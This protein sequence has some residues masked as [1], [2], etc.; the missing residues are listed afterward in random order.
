MRW[1]WPTV[2]PT[3]QVASGRKVSGGI[4]KR[5]SWERY[6]LSVKDHFLSAHEGNTR[7]FR[8]NSHH[9]DKSIIRPFSWSNLVRVSIPID[10]SKHYI[11]VYIHTYHDSTSP[12]SRLWLW[13]C[14]WGI[15]P[16]PRDCEVSYCLKSLPFWKTDRALFSQNFY[17]QE[18]LSFRK[19]QYIAQSAFLLTQYDSVWSLSECFTTL[20][21]WN[22]KFWLEL[23]HYSKKERLILHEPKANHF[24]V[25]RTY[26]SSS[27]HPI[28]GLSKM[29]H[30]IQF[31]FHER[32]LF[33]WVTFPNYLLWWLQNLLNS[34]LH[35]RDFSLSCFKFTALLAVIRDLLSSPSQIARQLES[36]FHK[37]PN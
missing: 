14:N 25:Y 1:I 12:A 11:I 8:G 2:F 20:N 10:F 18:N 21:A 4:L 28:I 15:N 19:T 24:I 34:D 13:Q 16:K 9:H 17:G 30:G 29:H 33:D 37:S 26:R 5:G 31:E 36:M 35:L 6:R 7:D 3:I 22:A 23:C 32:S 27:D